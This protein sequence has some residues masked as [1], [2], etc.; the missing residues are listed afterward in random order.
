M[1]INEIIREKR[2]K[3]KLTQEQMASY[4][5]VSAPAVN[6]W[7]KGVSF[8]DITLLPALARLLDTDLNTLL[9]FKEELSPKEIESFLEQALEEAQAGGVD[10][11]F[12]LAM[13]KLRE[14]PSCDLLVLNCALTLEG[15]LIM[16][17]KNGHRPDLLAEIEKLYERA[18]KSQELPV[19]WQAQ[20]MLFSK[21]VE[22]EEYEK[23]EE[24]L[25][26]L[27]DET[28]YNKNCLRANLCLKQKQWKEG[29]CIIEGD[30]LRSI[31]SVHSSML[32]LMD[33]ALKEH[34]MKDAVQL[35]EIIKDTGRL[36][37]LWDV[38]S[39]YAYFQ[40]AVIEEDTKKS[41]SAMKKMLS[42]LLKQWEIGKSPL[43]VHMETRK[44][45]RNMGEMMLP[46][47]IK[48]LEDPENNQ[49]DFLREEPDFQKILQVFKD[50]LSV[51]MS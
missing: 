21:Y 44:N 17:S 9:S 51:E 40:L 35:A 6:K 37:G 26:E 19:R 28:L 13:E 32:S 47:I 3:K 18:A 12:S 4:L 25:K 16:D 50:K 24:L 10:K 36:F 22:R 14:Y 15:L 7:E 33:I 23:A 11:G 42:S 45:E 48:E 41:L 30:L 31:L 39:H 38:S 34:R 27:P 5:G 2:T 20:S 46:G 49:Y 8:P 1:K 29:A 43:Y